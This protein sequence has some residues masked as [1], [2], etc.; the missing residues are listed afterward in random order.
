MEALLTGALGVVLAGYGLVATVLPRGTA[1]AG[2]ILD[3]RGSRDDLSEIEPTDTNV[4]LTR[5]S[6]IFT[7]GLGLSLLWGVV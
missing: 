6:G 1:A 2:E 4:V 7:L 3:A 5:V